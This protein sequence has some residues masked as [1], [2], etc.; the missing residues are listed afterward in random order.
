MLAG[1]V[2]VSKKEKEEK[3]E[4][5]KEMSPD[6]VTTERTTNKERG[7][8]WNAEMSKF[9][10]DDHDDGENGDSLQCRALLTGG[11]GRGRCL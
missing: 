1:G 3:K 2:T 9:Y 10:G 4:K 5:K 6:D 11:G 8:K 7:G